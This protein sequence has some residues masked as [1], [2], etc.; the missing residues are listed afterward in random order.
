[1]SELQTANPI[2]PP[3]NNQ[4]VLDE[5]KRQLSE[6]DIKEKIRERRELENKPSERKYKFEIPGDKTNKTKEV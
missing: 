1:M 4:K 2:Y 6:N 3:T 5:I